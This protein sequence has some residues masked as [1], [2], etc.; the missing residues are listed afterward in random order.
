MK[1]VHIMVLDKFIPS[2]IEFINENF[3]LTQHRFLVLGNKVEYSLP[4]V[5]NVINLVGDWN[6]FKI[7]YIL[8]SSMIR[9][10]K[11]FVHGMFNA[12]LISFLAVHNGFLKKCYWLVWGGDLYYDFIGESKLKRFLKWPFRKIVF[13]KMGHL[14]TPLE[15]DYRYA[16]EQFGARGIIH[17]T[18]LYPSN[19]FRGSNSFSELKT[20]STKN[21][22]IMIGNSATISNRHE[23]AFQFLM[24]H[25][26]GSFNLYVP[27]S[28][29][30]REY[31]QKIA[32]I[33]YKLFGKRFHPIFEFL[34]LAEYEAFLNSIDIVIF[35]HLRQQ[36]MG[37]SVQLLG[38]GKKLY[39]N[40]DVTP[41]EMFTKNG[42]KVYPLDEFS[43][44]RM[45][46]SLAAQ[47]KKC[48]QSIFNEDN[49]KRQWEVVFRTES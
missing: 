12:A 19:V 31:G 5:P 24:K 29:G 27:L 32:A 22:N 30:D 17:K 36:A 18:F 25:D 49:L 40:R 9:S 4:N 26:D 15:G 3:D 2:Y 16:V 44:E 20:R 21:I 46:P 39:M 14:V 28:Y 33:G 43:L 45:N 35:N 38:M 1:Y 7:Y 13:K 23:E 11:V 48:I 10:E 37:N 6:F 41:F 8:V 42:I 34:P 47:N